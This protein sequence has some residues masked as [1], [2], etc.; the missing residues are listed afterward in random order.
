[1][2]IIVIAG[3]YYPYFSA[4]GNCI[5]NVIQELKKEHNVIVLAEKNDFKLKKEYDYDGVTIIRINDYLTSFHK[6]CEDR[7]KNSNSI[8]S[9]YF[10]NCILQLKRIIFVIKGILRKEAVDNKKVKLYLN[11][12]EEISKKIKIDA[13]VPI[14]LPIEAAVAAKE[15]K[16]KYNTK[17]IGFQFDHFTEGVTINKF[18]FQ[19]K[20]RYN[21]HLAIKKEILGSIDKLLILP[22]LEEF[23]Q[24]EI[25]NEFKEKIVMSEHPLLMDRKFEDL[26]YE[27]YRLNVEKIKLVFTGTLVKRIRTPEYL[28]EIISNSNI[29]N[30]VSLNMFTNG[31]C[32]DILDSYAQEGNCS[33]INH[34]YVPLDIALYSMR[35]ADFLISIGVT[36]GNQVSGKIFDYFATGKPIVHFYYID[37]DPNLH[38]FKQYPLALCLKIDNDII[39]KN[40]K[41]F[42]E[43]IELN[44]GKTINYKDIEKVYD[45]ATPS[46]VTKQITSELK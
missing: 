40:I 6:W 41:L 13:V 26:K 35:E 44:N 9:R 21:K 8:V 11:E 28:L 39:D 42:S 15:F 25:F 37:N 1:M 33:I 4:N 23:Y 38:Y 2:N 7:K 14:I 18:K 16:K 19:E 5:N 24:K 45:Y 43:F 34:G 30:K 32:N 27:K 3:Y 20:L 10:Y 36:K 31:N 29:K 46:Y 17:V 22:Q 12:L